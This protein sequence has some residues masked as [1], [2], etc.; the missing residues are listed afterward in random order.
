MRENHI[1]VLSP[2]NE[3]ELAEFNEEYRVKIDTTLREAAK[4]SLD[5][6]HLSSEQHQP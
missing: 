4:G 3:A 2:R 5:V 1:V 6:Y